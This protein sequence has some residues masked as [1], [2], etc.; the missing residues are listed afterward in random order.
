VIFIHEDAVELGYNVMKWT[1][2]FVSL[3][4]SIV[5]TEK[6]DVMVNSEELSGTTEYL[7]L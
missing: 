1:E 6:Y 4:M 2:Y 7:M 5:I 3:Y